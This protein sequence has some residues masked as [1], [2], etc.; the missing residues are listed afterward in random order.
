VGVV[1]S[2]TKVGSLESGKNFSQD[3]SVTLDS[4]TD[5]ANLRVIAFVQQA[6]QRQVLGAAL[7]RVEK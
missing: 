7:Q 5:L 6:G 3:V 2:L 4:R 1:Q